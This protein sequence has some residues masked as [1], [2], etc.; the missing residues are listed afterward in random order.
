[1]EREKIEGE[2]EKA[3]YDLLVCTLLMHS[4]SLSV[5]VE[6]SLYTLKS[7]TW[8][9]PRSLYFLFQRANKPLN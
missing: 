4:H 7:S 3:N 2:G 8:P 9:H 1:M 5:R 6:V